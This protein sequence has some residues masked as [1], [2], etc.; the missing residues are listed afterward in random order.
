MPHYLVCDRCGYHNDAHEPTLTFCEQC[1]HK[2]S[3]CYS[4]WQ[5]RH[6]E[7]GIEAFWDSECVSEPTP[8]ASHSTAPQHS[9]TWIML[10]IGTLAITM[11]VVLLA[12]P[13]GRQAKRLTGFSPE[14][15]NFL[16]SDTSRWQEFC[17]DE[18]R[19]RVY[20][21]LG[22]PERIVNTA[23]TEVG[24]IDVVM[25]QLDMPTKQHPNM[26]YAVSFS[27]YPRNFIANY[28]SSDRDVDALF[29]GA[30]LSTMQGARAQLSAAYH[31][32]LG[33]YPGRAIEA[34]IKSTNCILSA[35]FYLINS[36]MFC[37]QVLT[38]ADSYPNAAADFFLS[39]FEVLQAD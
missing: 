15:I 4:A 28:V 38:P 10:A 18:G 1:G 17:G 16:S 12:L 8:A 29:E 19:F 23:S 37:L 26:V 35:R 27:V 20:M 21:P 6:P 32:P 30:I 14:E 5:Q 11:V 39:S 36:T 22:L 3:R 33:D 9:Q 34:E 24:S 7:Q 13:I 25:Y 2:L 31:S